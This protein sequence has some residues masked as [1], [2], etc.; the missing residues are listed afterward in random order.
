M[1]QLFTAVFLF[2]SV[3]LLAQKTSYNKFYK[4]HEEASQFSM[5]VPV[6]LANFL[7]DEEEAEEI[8]VL[9]K[10]AEHCKITVFNNEGNSLEKSFRKFVRSNGLETLVKVKDGKDRAAIYF[11]GK[12]DL[13]EEIIIKANSDEDKLVMVGLKV[14][15]TKDELA[16]V[17]SSM[18]DKKASR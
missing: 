16:D 13:I 14:S 17:I 7:S 8:E 6:S 4:A 1:K 11:K 5:S 9:L 2:F 10:K 12:N 15:L 3:T 18:K